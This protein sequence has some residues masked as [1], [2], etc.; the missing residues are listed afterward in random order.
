MLGVMKRLERVWRSFR[1]GEQVVLGLC[2]LLLA[3]FLG[4]AH[5]RRQSA[6]PLPPLFEEPAGSPV[7]SNSITSAT[8]TGRIMVHVSGA[9]RYPGVRQL[10]IGSRLVDA[11][12]AAGGLTPDGDT[13][14]INLASRLQDGQQVVLPARGERQSLVF[15]APT[16]TSQ[17][18]RDNNERAGKEIKPPPG[19]ITGKVNVNTATPEQ[20]ET[21][22]GVGPAI[23]A[24]IVQYRHQQGRLRSLED[25]DQVKGLGLKKLEALRDRVSF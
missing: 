7:K 2:A 9:V 15:S 3:L 19:G 18:N 4:I 20:L 11:V 23:A 5:V 24:R 8:T 22:P 25:L 1:P 13:S 14:S 21:L 17:G 12:H 16:T 10:P 6:E